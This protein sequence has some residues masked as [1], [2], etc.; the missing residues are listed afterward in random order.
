MPRRSLDEIFSQ[1]QEIDI[2]A[3]S[4]MDKEALTAQLLGGT[5][6]T[7][8]QPQRRSLDEIFGQETPEQPQMQPQQPQMPKR[9]VGMGE[10]VARALHM[11][12]ALALVMKSWADWV[13]L[14]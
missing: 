12:A 4:P 11:A 2:G 5:L 13:R 10:S 14:A 1:P 7:E 6:P 8:D 3:M 9:N